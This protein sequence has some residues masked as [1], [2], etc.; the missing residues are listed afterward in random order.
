MRATAF[1]LTLYFRTLLSMP[2]KVLFSTLLLFVVIETP[3]P[4][5]S[6]ALRRESPAVAAGITGVLSRVADSGGTRKMLP[7]LVWQSLPGE[8]MHDRVAHAK[9]CAMAI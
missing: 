6:N 8:A 4:V 2:S 5:A 9:V 7:Q 1:P 3:R